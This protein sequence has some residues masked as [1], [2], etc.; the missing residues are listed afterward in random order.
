[1]SE[2]NNP[3]SCPISQRTELYFVAMSSADVAALLQTIHDFDKDSA[4]R[5]LHTNELKHELINRL[6]TSSTSPD[7]VTDL[8]P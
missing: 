1:M 6:A 7:Q 5:L 2:T 4:E 3:T 8:P